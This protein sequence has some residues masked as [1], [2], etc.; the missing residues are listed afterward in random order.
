[1]VL[2]GEHRWSCS[3]WFLLQKTSGHCPPHGHWHRVRVLT[4]LWLIMM[5]SCALHFDPSS[6]QIFQ[7]IFGNYIL[8]GRPCPVQH[9]FGQEK[10]YLTPQTCH[11]PH[12]YLQKHLPDLQC[13]TQRNSLSQG[14]VLSVVKETSAQI[15]CISQPNKE[16]ETPGARTFH[17]IPVWE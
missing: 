14:Y 1:M 16:R 8:K 15:I 6:S 12:K 10:Y 9:D 11:S 3:C 2:C 7:R 13:R 4:R 5:I 17:P